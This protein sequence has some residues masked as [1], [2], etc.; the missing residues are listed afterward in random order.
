MGGRQTV[1]K[2]EILNDLGVTVVAVDALPRDVALVRNL[3]VGLLR[4]DLTEERRDQAL[5]WLLGQCLRR[6]GTPRR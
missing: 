5:D 1:Q 3:G 2:N 6:P 4:G